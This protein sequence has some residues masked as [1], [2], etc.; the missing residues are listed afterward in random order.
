M[1]GSRDKTG[2]TEIAGRGGGHAIGPTACAER[3]A[4]VEAEIDAGPSP[5]G[6]Q[7]PQERS[8]FFCSGGNRSIV[9][10]TTE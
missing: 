1:S 4:A 10:R 2:C 6:F 7:R 5:N 3:E 8:W 9:A